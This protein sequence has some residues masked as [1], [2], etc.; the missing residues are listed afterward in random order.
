MKSNHTGGYLGKILRV[1]LS[2]REVSDEQITPGWA[3]SFHCVQRSRSSF[4][5]AI[6]FVD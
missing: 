1:N 3:L 5:S 2:T 6:P 4:L